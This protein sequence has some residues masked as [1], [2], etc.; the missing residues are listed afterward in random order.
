MIEAGEP[1]TQRYLDEGTWTIEIAGRL[2]PAMAS[3]RPLYD[4]TSARVRA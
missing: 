2:Y 4:P 1:V 3:I